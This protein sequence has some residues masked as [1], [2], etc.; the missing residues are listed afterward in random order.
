MVRYHKYGFEH[1]LCNYYPQSSRKDTNNLLFDQTSKDEFL[2]NLAN[3]HG[4]LFTDGAER[5]VRGRDQRE[6]QKPC[7][8]QQGS[9]SQSQYWSILYSYR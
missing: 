5:I 6:R 1:E 9:C 4:F 3:S 8:S 2:L 7:R